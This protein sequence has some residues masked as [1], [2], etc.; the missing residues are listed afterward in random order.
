MLHMVWISKFCYIGVKHAEF[1]TGLGAFASPLVATQFAQLPR[2]S[3]HFLVSLGISIS[4]VIILVLV[5]K[6][7]DQDGKSI[8]I[9]RSLTPACSSFRVLIRMP[10][11][12][13]GG[14]A[15]KDT[16]ERRQ[17]FP[18]GPQD[19]SC[20]SDGNF[21]PH[22]RRCR[23]YYRRFVPK[24]TDLSSINPFLQGGS[25]HLSST[26]VVVALRLDIYLQAS[27]AVR[28]QLHICR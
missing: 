27:L 5:F 18:E 14:C 11:V 17:H 20:T 22:I 19:K 25:S 15:R 10:Q 16:R 21:H 4:N 26:N 8:C 24:K 9:F 12:G 7:K 3:F 6:F 13:R 2:W 23:S 1:L 28:G